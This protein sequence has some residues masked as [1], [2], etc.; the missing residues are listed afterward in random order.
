MQNRGQNRVRWH[1]QTSTD[2]IQNAVQN[3]APPQPLAIH[4]DDSSNSPP[5]TKSGFRTGLDQAKKLISVKAG[6]DDGIYDQNDNALGMWPVGTQIRY[7]LAHA[8]GSCPIPRVCHSPPDAASVVSSY[9]VVRCLISLA[10]IGGSVAQELVDLDWLQYTLHDIDDAPAI[11][12]GRILAAISVFLAF[13]ISDEL[14]KQIL[15]GVFHIFEFQKIVMDTSVSVAFPRILSLWVVIVSVYI[16]LLAQG[17]EFYDKRSR[18]VNTVI[19]I[20]Y[21]ISARLIN[22]FVFVMNA[23][24]ISY[25]TNWEHNGHKD[26]RLYQ[27]EQRF[28]IVYRMFVVELVSIVVHICILCTC[29]IKVRLWDTINMIA[30][31]IFGAAIFSTQ[32]KLKN[33][34][35]FLFLYWNRPFVIGQRVWLDGKL[36]IV[37]TFS[38]TATAMRLMSGDVVYIP[39][40]TFLD[41]KV[42][43]VD[44]AWKH[45]I[46]IFL[47]LKPCPSVKIKAL[48]K[49]LEDMCITLSPDLLSHPD[50]DTEERYGKPKLFF[51]YLHDPYTI[52]IYIFSNCYKF[53]A[54]KRMEHKV[55]TRIGE[56]LEEHMLELVWPHHM[57]I[58]IREGKKLIHEN[59]F[60]S[61]S[62]RPE[63][64]A[65]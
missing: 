23:M 46:D 45:K 35:G 48:I 20:A 12:R 54:F 24:V 31:L 17:E 52:R 56:L 65:I 3:T 11:T 49:S 38:L 1:E 14:P 37:M 42:G 43:N 50:N 47:K 63:T 26:R 7:K 16:A 57:D 64:K 21:V 19:I 55:N 61:Q 62:R 9:H 58:K 41:A 27:T 5:T 2:A 25:V 15:T 13:C 4:H 53:H 29:L 60:I 8:T 28:E 22:L 18:Y 40:M 39:N 59:L 30:S 10:M 51:V 34:M 36:Y 33:A 32:L 6:D 44:D